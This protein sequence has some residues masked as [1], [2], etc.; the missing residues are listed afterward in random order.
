MIL[1][2]LVVSLT[3][4]MIGCGDARVRMDPGAIMQEGILKGGLHPKMEIKEG[5]FKE[6][7]LKVERGAVEI[8]EG[9]FKGPAI[10]V[11]RE[12]IK[13]VVESGAVTIHEGAITLN[14][15]GKKKAPWIKTEDVRKALKK[16]EPLKGLEGVPEELRS[17]VTSNEKIMQSVIKAILDAIDKHNKKYAEPVK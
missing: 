11:E 4:L 8:K 17:R 10:N 16:L 1:P 6:P 5:A 3:T 12:A 2:I 13:F 9:A 7:I 15:I 14:L